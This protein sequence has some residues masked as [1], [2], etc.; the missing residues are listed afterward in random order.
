MSLEE[1][2]QQASL[3][4]LGLLEGDELADFERALATNPTLQTLVAEFENASVQL[5]QSA[6]PASPPPAL[7]DTIMREISNL[8]RAAE[9]A[10]SRRSSMAVLPWALAAGFAV[11]AGFTWTAAKNTE[12][13]F[14]EASQRSIA[15]SGGFSKQ[16][17]ALVS[18]NSQLLNQ[19]VELGAE[20][21]RLEIRLSN[22]EAEKNQL[23]LRM[24]SLEARDP[25]SD[26]RAISF[27][28]QPEAP[29][30]AEVAALWDTRRQAG[31]L[32]LSKLPAPAADKDY[33]LWILSPDSAAPISA[34][35]VSTS[36]PQTNFRSPR[37][38]TQVAALALSLEPKG[39]SDSPRGPVIYV[40]K[41]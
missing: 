31:V 1:R 34:G 8:R 41:F 11:F 36:A 4:A 25:L 28:P 33:Q 32:D 13:D 21:T 19:L 40:G 5:A 22:L 24:T 17:A 10:P 14:K 2:E 9:P 38:L 7:K 29:K 39:G 16:T 3:Y 23:K 15:L 20:R 12:R 30:G 6:P 27:A 37:P 26:I 18:Q 35:V